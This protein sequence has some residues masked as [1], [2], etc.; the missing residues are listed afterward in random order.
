M[1]NILKTKFNVKIIGCILYALG[2]AF[3]WSD[4]GLKM[5][6]T[7]LIECI[8]KKFK[9]EDSNPVSVPMQKGMKPLTE[10]CPKTDDGKALKQVPFHSAVGALLYVALCTCPEITYSVCSLACFSQNPGNIHWSGVKNIIKYLL[11]TKEMGISYHFRQTPCVATDLNPVGWSDYHLMILIMVI[12]PWVMLSLSM[13]SSLVGR[14]RC[15]LL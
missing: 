8:A 15:L 9:L 3:T 2:I 1:H 13:G 5:T 11:H 7:A 6:Q 14:Q 10:H 12:L 4:N